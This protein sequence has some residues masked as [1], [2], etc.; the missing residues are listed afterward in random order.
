MS[1]VHRLIVQLLYG[2]GLQLRE[3]MRLR[4]K[5]PDFPQSQIVVRDAKSPRKTTHD[6]TQQSV[7]AA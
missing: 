5:D 7:D 2:S 4:I 1:G 3:V 6:A